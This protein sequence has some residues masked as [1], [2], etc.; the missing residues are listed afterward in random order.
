MEFGRYT[1]V[2]NYWDKKG[3]NEIDIIALSDLDKVAPVAEVKRNPARI[4]LAILRA[5]A[6][7]LQDRLSGYRSNIEAF[8]LTDM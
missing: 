6:A 8:S 5:K 3:E 2:G 7:T 4:Y 1:E